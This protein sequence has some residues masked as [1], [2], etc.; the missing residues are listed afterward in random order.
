M[1]TWPAAQCNQRL[2]L[3]GTSWQPGTVTAK[4]DNGTQAT[5]NFNAI[6]AARRPVAGR[7]TV[8][9]TGIIITTTH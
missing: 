3:A 1:V 5:A 6:A 8:T 7:A 9:V 2:V 4:P